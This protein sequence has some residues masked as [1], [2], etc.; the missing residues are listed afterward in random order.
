MLTDVKL[1]QWL[2]FPWAADSCLWSGEVANRVTIKRCY[3]RQCGAVGVDPST[4]CKW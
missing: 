4:W 2:G 3:Q 1:R